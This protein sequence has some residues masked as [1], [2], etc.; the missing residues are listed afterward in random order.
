[1]RAAAASTNGKVR[2][3]R[4]VLFEHE[5]RRAATAA[6]PRRPAVGAR[7]TT[8]HAASRGGRHKHASGGSSGA[9]DECRPHTTIRGVRG[10]EDRTLEEAPPAGG[11]LLPG[12]KSAGPVKP[13]FIDD[14]PSAKVPKSWLKESP[15]NY[16]SKPGATKPRSVRGRRPKLAAGPDHELSAL[17]KRVVEYENAWAARWDTEDAE[18]E[19]RGRSRSRSRSRSPRGRKGT[20]PLG[21]DTM[22]E[23]EAR[24]ASPRQRTADLSGS[25]EQMLS[26]AS[27]S[28]RSTRSRSRSR[29]GSGSADGGVS[30]WTDG[31][32]SKPP[33]VAD[34][35]ATGEL[36][37]LAQ[38]AENAAATRI[39]AR[40]RGAAV[41]KTA[42]AAG[43]MRER[44]IAEKHR[45]AG[46]AVKIQSAQRAKVA[47]REVDEV[48]KRKNAAAV[49]IQKHAK[50][51]QAR[52]KVKQQRQEAVERQD[53]AARTIQSAAR[54]TSARRTARQLAGLKD[55]LLRRQR[56]IEEAAA[57][58]E[59]LVVPGAP[60]VVEDV[61]AA[62]NE[63]TREQFE[64][65]AAL[66]ETPALVA[67]FSALCI[68]MRAEPT[69]A[70]AQEQLRKPSFKSIISVLEHGH[71]KPAARMT[72]RKLLINADVIAQHKDSKVPGLAALSNWVGMVV[73]EQKIAVTKE[74]L[75]DEA[76][77]A[78]E[79]AVAA[80]SRG[81]RVDTVSFT[82][83]QRIEAGLQDK[84]NPAPS[85]NLAFLRR[86]RER[87]LE[88][89][90]EDY[91]E[92]STQ[93]TP[94]E[95]L[96]G[97]A[98]ALDTLYSFK[99]PSWSATRKMLG[100]PA[101]I[102]ACVE[103]SPLDVDRRSLAMAALL[104]LQRNVRAIPYQKDA[105]KAEKALAMWLTAFTATEDRHVQVERLDPAAS[106]TA[107]LAAAGEARVRNV[108]VEA[109]DA[110]ST[111][112]EK[113]VGAR[114]QVAVLT[115]QQRL[116]AALLNPAKAIKNIDQEFFERAREELR[117]LRDM[118]LLSLAA[119]T[120]P[121]PD[122]VV[123]AAA[124]CSLIESPAKWKSMRKMLRQSKFL[125]VLLQLT[126]QKVSVSQA[127][128]CGRYGPV[129]SREPAVGSHNTWVRCVS[130]LRC[131]RRRA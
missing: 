43:E 88:L 70:N 87:V 113:S 97:I 102:R 20:S 15:Y 35:T 75:R 59:P 52:K 17:D 72:A 53:Q 23:P 16:T 67:L 61:V 126:P 108:A 90:M 128:P 12:G 55:A 74:D 6:Q 127:P 40:A 41:R 42:P 2:P 39:Q 116:K 100:S 18:R 54:G 71:V 37:M 80:H 13:H 121:P 14:K 51:A 115:A 3:Q 33:N 104:C 84:H 31:A 130:A 107:K 94:T 4:S 26:S 119:L 32:A 92:I 48:R 22:L 21:R 10:A 49:T 8:S 58:G 93:E 99:E 76:K 46:A 30:R 5:P 45:K 62:L 68:L 77:R 64:T 29:S 65:I 28:P 56:L 19:G 129:S 109:V 105:G 103:L 86:S 73:S 36:E 117:N 78:L 25:Y 1:M 125:T 66:K 123:V 81:T 27:A 110:F 112:Q 95:N 50:G 91:A 24:A 7:A 63:V 11:R 79:R 111:L 118:D 114:S 82:A 131:C 69:Y 9:A 122:A 85:I 34:F 98:A 38:D 89:T 47:R 106:E 101:V 83:E 60:E 44:V 57:K 120:T 96:I 124:L